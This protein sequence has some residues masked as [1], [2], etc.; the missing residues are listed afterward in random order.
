M[1]TFEKFKKALIEM[2]KA[3]E[4]DKILKASKRSERSNIKHDIALIEACV[5]YYEAHD[6]MISSFSAIPIVYE[7]KSADV[8]KNALCYMLKYDEKEEEA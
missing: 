4:L 6:K 5:E 3:G 1:T 2:Y 8:F 7:L